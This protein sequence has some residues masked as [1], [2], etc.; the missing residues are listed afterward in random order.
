MQGY[1]LFA[2]ETIVQG[3]LVRHLF[4]DPH[5]SFT[6]NQVWQERE[7]SSDFHIFTRE[8]VEKADWSEETR[9]LFYNFSYQ[10]TSIISQALLFIEA[11]R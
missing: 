7:D 2:T 3:E 5:F 10:V 4:L 11:H 6:G 9:N 8:E 1:G